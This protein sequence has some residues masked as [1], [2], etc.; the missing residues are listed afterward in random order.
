MA[1]ILSGL[2]IRCTG[3]YTKT[4]KV[5]YALISKIEAALRRI[6]KVNVKALDRKRIRV[7]PRYK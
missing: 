4:C 2:R 5:L 1:G 6:F 7:R 3:I